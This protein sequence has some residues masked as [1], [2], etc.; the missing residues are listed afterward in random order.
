MPRARCTSAIGTA[1]CRYV[2]YVQFATQERRRDVLFLG[3]SVL[4]PMGRFVN[5]D[6]VVSTGVDSVLVRRDRYTPAM[7]K[8][9][10]NVLS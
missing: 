5:V 6:V 4:M 8:G 9:Q 10:S 3:G 1:K 2:D 7:Y